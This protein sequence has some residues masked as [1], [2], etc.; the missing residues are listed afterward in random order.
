MEANRKSLELVVIMD[1]HELHIAT[2]G[3]K[4]LEKENEN[5]N[6]KLH[7]QIDDLGKSIETIEH[8]QLSV[9]G[10][11]YHVSIIQEQL[12]DL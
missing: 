2:K 1:V 9:Q 8:L 6:I 7:S 12:E 5:L 4:R 11:S 10:L 3:A